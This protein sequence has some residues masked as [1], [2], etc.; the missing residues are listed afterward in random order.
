MVV[1]VAELVVPSFA[2]SSAISPAAG[3]TGRT[4]PRRAAPPVSS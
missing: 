4:G 2:W 3:G 1:M